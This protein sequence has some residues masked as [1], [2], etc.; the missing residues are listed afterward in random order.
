MNILISDEKKLK[1]FGKVSNCVG[2]SRRFADCSEKVF[3][4]ISGQAQR[5]V[6]LVSFVT[7][8]SVEKNIPGSQIPTSGLATKKAFFFNQKFRNTARPSTLPGTLLRGKI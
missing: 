6:I 1:F 7:S 5:E 4:E 8:C 3:A 2:S